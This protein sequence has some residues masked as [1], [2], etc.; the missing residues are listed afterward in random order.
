MAFDGITIANLVY[1]LNQKIVSGRIAKIAQPEKDELLL[2]HKGSRENFRLLIS[3]NASLP[4]LYFTETNKPS[5][6]TAPNFCM[7]LR[8]HIANGRILSVTQPGFER[9]V[10]FEIEHLDEMGDLRRKYLIVELMGK[11]SNIIFCDENDMILDSIKHISA[12]SSV[13][14]C[15]R[16]APIFIPLRGKEKSPGDHGGGIYPSDP[17]NTPASVQGPLYGSY[18]LK[19]RW[20]RQRSAIW[21]PWTGTFPPRN[22]PKVS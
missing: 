21:P 4:L 2:S 20:R 12:R 6:M 10:R 7:L 17:G 1:D 13:R 9:I 22:F 18:R 8:K 3:A 15:C 11:H 14:R 19:P 16:D 5:P